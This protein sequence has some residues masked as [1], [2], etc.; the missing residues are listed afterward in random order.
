MRK[1]LS[2]ILAIAMMASVFCCPVSVAAEEQ[3]APVA[4][5]LTVP[6]QVL[7]GLGF[8]QR[9][10]Y[11]PDALVSRADFAY[12]VATMCG[13]VDQNAAYNDNVDY[14]Y[15]ADTKDTFI[16][17]NDQIFD[18]VDSTLPEYE[19][20]NA[21]YK[22]GYMNGVTL[23]H[24]GPYYDIT[25]AQVVKV[26]VS[27]LG[28]GELA[29]YKGGFPGGYMTV[30]SSLKLLSG[31]NNRNDEFVTYRQAIDVV[32]N[33][34][35]INIYEMTG[36]GS[37]GE[38]IHTK[39]DK[40]FLNQ[41]INLYKVTGILSD[42][43]ISGFYGPS[44][45]GA[46]KVVIGSE[47]IAI[48][49]EEYIRPLLGREVEAYY[50]DATGE[51]TLV[52]AF[53]TGEDSSVSFSIDDFGSYDYSSITYYDGD[54]RVTKSISSGAR[55]IYNNAIM[56]TYT[57]DVFDFIF[58]DVTLASSKGSGSYDL[59]I[60]NDYM[61]GKINKIVSSTNT[62]YAET[63]YSGMN[64]VKTLDLSDSSSHSV[65]ITDANGVPMTFEALSVGNVVSVTKS[66][67]GSF[68]GV[69]VCTAGVQNFELKDYV[70]SNNLEIS[71]GTSTYFLKDVAS[72]EDNLILRA[73]ELYDLY[74]DYEGNLIWIEALADTTDLRRGILMGVAND[75]T[76]LNSSYAIKL[77]TTDGVFAVYDLE[78]KVILNHESVKTENAYDEILAAV[79]DV[80]LYRA[81]D[82]AG[83]LKAIVL[84]VKYGEPD[85]ENRGWYEIAP[86]IELSR[87]EGMSQSD[88]EKQQKES[89]YYISMYGGGIGRYAIY[90][91]SLTTMFG[92]PAAREDYE[93]EKLFSV[94]KLKLGELTRRYLNLYDTNRY[95]ITPDVAVMAATGGT[96]EEVET[97]A[98]F[99][100][101]KVG[102]TLNDEGEEAHVLKGYLMD[103][104]ASGAIKELTLP[105][106]DNAE[107]V[108]AGATGNINPIDPTA[109]EYDIVKDGPSRVDQLE[110]GDI[111]RYN[112]N[113]YGEITA[114]RMA[115]DY[116]TGSSFLAGT[117]QT[118]DA[119]KD[120]LVAHG[121]T[122][123]GYP[124][125]RE[126]NFLRL[127]AEE[128]H[129]VD[130]DD[131]E[132]MMLG[133]NTAVHEV[134]TSVLIVE[135]APKG[136]SVRMGTIDDIITYEESGTLES[137][138][139]DVS[140]YNKVVIMA[141]YADGYGTV[142]YK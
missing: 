100:I 4:I 69:K 131:G 49:N 94:N 87:P 42:N 85:N 16:T 95:A 32:Y 24:F 110:P 121:F 6:E 68:V 130:P 78:D 52:Y 41:C 62:V 96:S 33:A 5:E 132:T 30:G 8:V 45:V 14:T 91:K 27:M 103:L 107:L 98:A 59:I 34:F 51:N 40:T 89:Y 48:G 81:D 127:T 129:L 44:L 1:I 65:L 55:L 63:M 138:D 113:S 21:M 70:E 56:D 75:S 88:W 109:P 102:N 82:K 23:S 43:G 15:G 58:G 3:T 47:R 117:I 29:E 25:M 17:T 135:Q 137:D 31:Y 84:P 2:Y 120:H 141:Y 122:F 97:R 139:P 118:G 67:D 79:D 18:D 50:T 10:G 19:A 13:F 111:I 66:R 125:T 76:G 46:D 74:F 105:I 124:L 128:P 90:N 133:K 77:Y 112:T 126:G 20:I 92:V 57:D 104:M 93:A 101:T 115:Y 72:L 134:T 12:L 53:A 54:R 140:L 38:E 22:S 7:M 61:V 108:T 142:V 64:N 136:I 114:I 28:Y 86:H 11:D 116:D 123:A 83:T 35:D 37:D 119:F 80:V 60:V 26:L 99:L 9:E 71:D 39:S 36:I 106:A 73:G